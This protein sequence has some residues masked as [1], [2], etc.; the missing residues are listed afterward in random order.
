[1]IEPVIG[2][3]VMVKTAEFVSGGG[4]SSL[5]SGQIF[6]ALV[7]GFIGALVS[8]FLFPVIKR[9]L[10]KYVSNEQLD[11]ADSIIDKLTKFKSN[12]D[13]DPNR[14][15]PIEKMLRYADLAVTAAQQQLSPDAKEDKKALAMTLAEGMLV[16][17]KTYIGESDSAMSETEKTIMSGLIETAIGFQKKTSRLLP[18]EP[19]PKE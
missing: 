11:V 9:T 7:V 19:S 1:M 15:D 14:E 12:F 8:F 6:G 2:T 17:Y 4:M 13:M 18:L 16:K 5:F 3:G 10:R